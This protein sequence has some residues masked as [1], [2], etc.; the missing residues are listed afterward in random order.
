MKRNRLKS[1]CIEICS[2]INNIYPTYMNEIF[3]LRKISRMVHSNCKLNLDV[4]TISQVGFGS[5]NLRYYKPKIW[6]LPSFHTKSS[7]NLEAFINF[8]IWNDVYCM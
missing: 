7:G 4:L 8:K 6:N 1:I 3:K 2:L 5:K